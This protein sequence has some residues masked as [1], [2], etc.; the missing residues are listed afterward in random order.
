MKYTNDIESLSE[1]DLDIIN[2]KTTEDEKKDESCM[3]GVEGS[4]IVPEEKLALKLGF[5]LPTSS[6]ATMAI[7]EL[8]KSSSLVNIFFSLFIICTSF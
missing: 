3:T 1:T 8:L 2:K 5:T 6:Y 4:H 7:R